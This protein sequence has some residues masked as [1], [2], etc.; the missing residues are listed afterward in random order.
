MIMALLNI[1]L[2]L[3]IVCTM[4][5][6]TTS[7][8]EYIFNGIVHIILLLTMTHNIINVHNKLEINTRTH[9]KYSFTTFKFVFYRNCSTFNCLHW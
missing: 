4:Y 8:K 2:L 5:Y 7:S 6:G 9:K 3:K 1:I